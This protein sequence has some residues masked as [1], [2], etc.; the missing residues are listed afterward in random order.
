MA[1]RASLPQ[2]LKF[3]TSSLV[4]DFFR[5]LLGPVLLVWHTMRFARAPIFAILVAFVGL[6]ACAAEGAPGAQPPLPKSPLIVEAAGGPVRFTVELADEPQ[7][8]QT[9]MMFRQSI[10]ELEGMLFDMGRPRTAI[11]WM[12]NTIIPLD[13]IFIDADGRILNIAAN[14]TPLSEEPLPSN[15]PARG[16]LEI[17]GG[18]AT[19]LGIEAGD[20]VHHTIFGNAPPP[21]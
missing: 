21:N 3:S 12:R 4:F 1:Q 17:G 11:F 13:I 2:R 10:G 8:T 14:A 16:V 5:N 6:A 15:G 18:R 9:G 19:E 7:E 20:L